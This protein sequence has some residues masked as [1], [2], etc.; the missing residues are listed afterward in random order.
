[1]MTTP[2]WRKAA[3]TPHLACG[4][5]HMFS[6]LHGDCIIVHG[7]LGSVMEHQET[8]ERKWLAIEDLFAFG[9]TKELKL[10]LDSSDDEHTP[11]ALMDKVGPVDILSKLMKELTAWQECSNGTFAVHPFAYDWRKEP[12][13]ASDNLVDFASSIYK[14][15]GGKPVTVIAHSMGGLITLSAVNK[16]PELFRGVVL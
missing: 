1:M 14:S 9:H 4:H 13:L 16:R 5:S 3:A 6:F 12:L 10:P 15:N 7:Y 8:K 2:T 11:V